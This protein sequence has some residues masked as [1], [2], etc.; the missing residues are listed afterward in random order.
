MRQILTGTVLLDR[1]VVQDFALEGFQPRST[2]IVDVAENAFK[3]FD[4]LL[5][6][7]Y[8]GALG[9]WL[10]SSRQQLFIAGGIEKFSNHVANYKGAKKL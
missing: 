9:T 1:C 6:M 4:G 3:G 2:F 8:I 5:G 10:S 7:D